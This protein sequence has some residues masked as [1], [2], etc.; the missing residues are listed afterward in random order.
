MPTRF[1]LL[2]CL[3]ALGCGLASASS[4]AP[5]AVAL[6]SDTREISLA[7][8]TR[9][10]VDPS[11]RDDAATSFERFARGEFA[12]LPP[13]GPT[14]GFSDGA[15]WFHAEIYN[16][17][18]AESRWLLVLDYPLLDNADIYV[19]YPDGRTENMASGDRLPFASRSI[20]YRQ[21]NFWIELPRDTRVEVMVRVTTRSS[22][23]VPLKLYTPSAFA[24]ME[25]DAQFG[26][27]VYN[28]ILIALLLY[29]LVLWLLLR[30][31]S[32]LWY[33]F[34]VGAFGLL[35]L[36]LYGLAF[37]YLWPNS[38]WWANQVIPLMMCA[39][40][41]AMH[42][43][44][45]TFLDLRQNWPLGDV[46]SRSFIAL[47]SLI[48]LASFF[49]DYRWSVLP[50]TALVFPGVSLVLVQAVYMLRKGYQP[51]RLF[52]IA[53][54]AMLLGSAIYATVSLGWLP[55]VFVTEFGIQIGSALEMILLSLAVASRYADLR[56]ENVRLIRDTNEQLE[57]KVASRTSELSLALEQLADVNARLRESSRRD[58]LTGV[59]N[60]RHFREVFEEMLERSADTREPVGVMLI[61]LDHF[62]RINDSYGHLAG[63]ECLKTTVS[64][65]GRSLEGIDALL[66]RFGGEE[67]VI[68]IP[69]GAA[70]RLEEIAER[71]RNRIASETVTYEG[72]R[73]SLTASFGLCMAVRGQR[74]RA[75]ALLQQADA[76]LYQAK[77]DGRNCVRMAETSAVG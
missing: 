10:R 30:D 64:V 62:K 3:W 19:R 57:R 55:K 59:Y 6:E 40:Q 60:R 36:C 56:A 12:P 71:L 9:Y 74:Q 47:Y 5:V 48:G 33:M 44:A 50:T 37:E 68:V 38:P 51:A 8:Y 39:S 70:D 31:S 61:D 63:D 22:M 32:Y 16:R 34:H 42:Q 25:R 75:D 27:G 1:A 7:P 72:R 20:G 17:N 28:G 35:L 21:P 76:A 66:A 58:A 18:S 73:I 46:L 54:S 69:G 52:L 4:S 41:V 67:F 24:E 43:F 53:W 2:L 45:R 15:Y 77:R 29:N 26:M 65:L 13:G 49:V 11:L 23:Q 14:F